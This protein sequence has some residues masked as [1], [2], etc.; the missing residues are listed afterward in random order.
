MLIIVPGAERRAGRFVAGE[1]FSLNNDGADAI[2]EEELRIVQIDAGGERPLAVGEGVGA[3][4]RNRNGFAQE[5]ITLRERLSEIRVGR[6]RDLSVQVNDRIRLGLT[7]ESRRGDVC[8]QVA[9][10]FRLGDDAAVAA[11]RNG[12]DAAC[13]EPEL[14][15]RS[16]G[17]DGDLQRSAARTK[18]GVNRIS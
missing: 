1:V 14:D 16:D 12:I 7:L 10:G 6:V 2:A 9:G 8:D 5:D 11:R 17:I 4:E 13:A 3:V 15:W 18:G